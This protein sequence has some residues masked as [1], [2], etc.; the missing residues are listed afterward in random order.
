MNATRFALFAL[1]T[2]ACATTALAQG[3][4]SCATA[5]IVVATGQFAFDT[6]AATTDGI[7]D[8][9][10]QNAAHNQIYLD[11]W[12]SWT[13]PASGSYTFATCGQTTLDSRIAVYDGS[14][15]GA[16]LACNDDGCDGLRSTVDV[17][18]TAG[19]VYIVRLGGYS[20]TVGGTGTFSISVTGQLLVLDTQVNPNNGKT[21]H[22]LAAGTW[23]AAEGTAVSLGGHLATIDDATESA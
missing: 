16:I 11:V 12:Y 8:P 3:S 1:F 13:A 14:C 21:Y 18:V 9:L 2:S 15:A 17:I 22:L 10:C 4:D 5:Q 23:T 19:N 6:T 7:G 20:Q